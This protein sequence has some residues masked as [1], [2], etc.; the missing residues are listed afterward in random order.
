[1]ISTAAAWPP[2]VRNPEAE[3]PYP[4][5]ITHSPH[6]VGTQ[7]TRFARSDII[8]STIATAARNCTTCQNDPYQWVE[9]LADDPECF[10]EQSKL[11]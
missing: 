6:W 10:S 3:W 8:T 2:L 1:M 7:I 11:N 9:N 4:A 5:I